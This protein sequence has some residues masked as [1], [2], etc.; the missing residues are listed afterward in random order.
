MTSNGE[1]VEQ[2]FEKFIKADLITVI[3]LSVDVMKI[4]KKS[5]SH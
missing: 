5:N 2:R 4:L 1:K 3:S